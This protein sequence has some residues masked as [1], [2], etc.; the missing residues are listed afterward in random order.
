MHIVKH[1]KL[2]QDWGSGKTEGCTK[3]SGHEH[4]QNIPQQ[5]GLLTVLAPALPCNTQAGQAVQMQ[6]CDRKKI[7]WQE[8]SLPCGGC[9]KSSARR[10][11]TLAQGR[12]FV[13]AAKVAV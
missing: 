2:G 9:M 13:G 6:R 11:D 3:L 7:A 10:V 12:L 8:M 4:A 5:A 1:D